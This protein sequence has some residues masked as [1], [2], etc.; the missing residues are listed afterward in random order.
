M[1]DLE[2]RVPSPHYLRLTLE[3]RAL[4]LNNFDDPILT[5]TR[6]CVQPSLSDELITA[7]LHEA[8]SAMERK[9]N[10][11][12]Y[13]GNS[14]L[15]ILSGEETSTSEEEDEEEKEFHIDS[16]VIGG[17]H[18]PVIT[19]WL[20]RHFLIQPNNTLSRG[21]IYRAYIEHCQR[22]NLTH[23][24]PATFGKVLRSVFPD[25]KTRRIGTRGNSRYHYC[26][27]GIKLKTVR[28][29]EIE[30]D[31]TSISETSNIVV[32]HSQELLPLLHS[33]PTCKDLGLPETENQVVEEFL[34]LTYRWHAVRILDCILRAEFY[35]IKDIICEFWRSVP[36][37][38]LSALSVPLVV[39]A[40]ERCDQILYRT[41]NGILLPQIL[42][43]LPTGL[44]LT[45]KNFV[46]NLLYW[47]QHGLDSIPP[48]IKYAKIR[49]CHQFKTSFMRQ[50]QI[51]HMS[52]T[53]NIVVMSPNIARTIQ[54]G[55]RL[56]QQSLRNNPLLCS[57]DSAGQ[58]L[59][60]LF[61][62]EYGS[63][64]DSSCSLSQ[65]LNWVES[66]V[67]KSMEKIT[68]LSQNKPR[69]RGELVRQL[70]LEWAFICTQILKIL[71]FISPSALGPLQLLEMLYRDYM[72]FL[73]E[74][75]DVHLLK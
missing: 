44:M 33:F 67:L 9:S 51:N 64:W 43:L 59:L 56:L 18:G 65:H 10:D 4:C 74:R 17:A 31:I 11:M 49:A 73:L 48:V 45:L 37:S 1:K 12:Q 16:P 5:S 35:Q 36:I 24:N 69:L 70:V 38:T 60:A 8:K 23:C 34:D 28:D 27:I 52:I 32:E 72:L 15:T 26:G 63:L 75:W 21:E 61:L 39:A 55:W 71:T 54:W 19:K 50:I 13:R 29:N 68:R 41:I 66:V 58:E 14:G 7:E 2:Y 30:E 6:L 22:N 20:Q 57:Q 53:A 62:Q 3:D 40:I 42:T 46:K 25:I 47:H